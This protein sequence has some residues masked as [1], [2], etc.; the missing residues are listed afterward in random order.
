MTDHHRRRERN[1]TEV[2]TP[3]EPEPVGGVVANVNPPEPLSK[4]ERYAA[5]FECLALVTHDYNHRD[6]V[7]S[8]V[9]PTVSVQFMRE[10]LRYVVRCV[11]TVRTL[12]AELAV[13]DELAALHASFAYIEGRPLNDTPTE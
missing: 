2:A 1:G 7:E 5:L 9:G 6:Y 4:Y 13:R 12:E 3:V 10:V 11:P 8:I